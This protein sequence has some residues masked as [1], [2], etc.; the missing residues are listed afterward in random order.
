MSGSELSQV[1]APSKA[2]SALLF[3]LIEDIS[4]HGEQ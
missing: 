2:D 4:D 1:G 3:G